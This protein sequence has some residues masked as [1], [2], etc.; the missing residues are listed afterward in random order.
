MARAAGPAAVPPPGKRP[1]DVAVALARMERAVADQPKAALFELYDEGFRSPFQQLVACLISIRTLD[2]V[3]L[4][5]ARRLLE[6]AP[7]AADL[8]ALPIDTVD[9]LLDRC[10]FHAAKARQ[11][12]VIAGDVV[13]RHGGDLPCDEQVLQGYHGVGPKTVNLV[14]GIACGQPRLG[15]AIHVWRVANRWGIVQARTPEVAISQLEAIV[16]QADWV[17]LNRLLVPFG[18]HVCT[19]AAPHCSTCPVLDMCRQIGV[20]RH[21]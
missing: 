18:K 2:E 16:P 20:F 5:V 19:R 17:H 4:P 3:T 21:R 6:R 11:L 13:T 8:V 7:T 14:L 9:R 10:T 15:V 12:L 1:F